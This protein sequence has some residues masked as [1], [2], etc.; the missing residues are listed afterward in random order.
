MLK[1]DQA[2]EVLSAVNK[3]QYSQQKMNTKH[4]I[5]SNRLQKKKKGKIVS[6]SNCCSKYIFVKVIDS[7]TLNTFQRESMETSYNRQ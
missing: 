1:K 7:L 5:V 2:Q 6:Y 4:V 3:Q